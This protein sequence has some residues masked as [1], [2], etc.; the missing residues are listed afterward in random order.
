MLEKNYKTNAMS[1]KTPLNSTLGAL[2]GTVSLNST[3]I[4]I[5]DSPDNLSRDESYCFAYRLILI[6]VSCDNTQNSQLN[7][8]D[9]PKEF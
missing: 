7:I 1:I 6:D 5:P 9:I 8:H 3:G 4:E 2:R